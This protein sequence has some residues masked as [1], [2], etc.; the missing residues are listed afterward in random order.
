MT[1]ENGSCK[2]HGPASQKPIYFA[3]PNSSPMHSRPARAPLFIDQLLQPFTQTSNQR[4]GHHMHIS[5]TVDQ[6][7]SSCFIFQAVSSPAA[8]FQPLYVPA[9]SRLN[10]Q[11]PL[12]AQAN[13]SIFNQPLNAQ[14]QR[15]LFQQLL[16]NVQQLRKAKPNA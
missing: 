6:T 13:V 16:V 8:T 12:N 7:Y 9:V 15:F 10:D 2:A 14:L 11:Q 4:F 1:Q 5:H 3:R